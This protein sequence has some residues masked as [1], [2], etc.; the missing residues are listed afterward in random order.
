MGNWAYNSY[1]SFLLGDKYF[2]SLVQKGYEFTTEEH[3]HQISAKSFCPEFHIFCVP[4]TYISIGNEG[5]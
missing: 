1:N 3:R 4:N 5:K 2:V